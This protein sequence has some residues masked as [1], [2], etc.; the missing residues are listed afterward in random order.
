[1]DYGIKRI[2]SP[3]HELYNVSSDNKYNEFLASD[4]NKEVSD[5]FVNFPQM[6]L[7]FVIKSA[8]NIINNN[9]K[10]LIK[11]LSDNVIYDLQNSF[12]NILYKSILISYPRPVFKGSSMVS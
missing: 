9:S 12:K 1:M 5:N 2:I 3:N 6:C 11:N 10:T 7:T 8:F 4:E